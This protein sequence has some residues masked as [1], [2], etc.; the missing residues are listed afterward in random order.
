[1]SPVHLAIIC[2]VLDDQ[3]PAGIETIALAQDL[4]ERG[5]RVSLI[6]LSA[7]DISLDPRVNLIV[8]G[9]KPRWIGL[10]LMRYQRWLHQ[11]IQAIQPDEAIS[12]HTA[13]AATIVVPLDGTDQARRR[14][15]RSMCSN[16][17]S[18]VAQHSREL[19]PGS[20][21]R[22]VFERRT[23]TRDTAKVYFAISETIKSQ[24]QE[25]VTNESASIELVSLPCRENPIDS[26]QAARLREQLSR[27]WGLDT[28]RYWIA[29]PFLDAYLDGFEAMI[30]AFKPLVEQ[31]LDAVLLL[32]GPTRYTHLA[33]I[34]QLALRDRV[35]FVGPTQRLPEIMAASDLVVS[36]TSHDP[37]GWALRPALNLEKPLI[38]TT[39]SGIAD[40]IAAPSGAVLRS[41]AQPEDL[42]EAIRDQHSRSG[43][44]GTKPKNTG[45]TPPEAPHLAD[46]IVQWVERGSDPN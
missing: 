22:Q 9:P 37:A 34:G 17:I 42:L 20:V 21:I 41:P 31:G 44:I 2:G 10:A 14:V 1:M 8:F 38:T 11:K 3:Q 6:A 16:I 29:F 27:A 30:R 35:R 25:D 15:K 26:S 33:W 19:M 24:L 18:T 13:L 12:M 43:D 7:N 39:A 40:E 4:A 28:D 5:F 45:S 23:M 36:P 32:A 46:A